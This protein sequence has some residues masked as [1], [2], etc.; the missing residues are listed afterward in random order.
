MLISKSSVNILIHIL[1]PN[2]EI[3][4][5]RGIPKPFSHTY[6]DPDPFHIFP[7]SNNL[8]PP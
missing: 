2:V 4:S 8:L 5:L 1:S 6:G 7:K 3:S